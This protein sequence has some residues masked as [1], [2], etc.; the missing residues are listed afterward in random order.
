MR[1]ESSGDVQSPLH[2]RGDED[3]LQAL[4]RQRDSRF[5]MLRILAILLITAHH[6]L[7]FGADVCGYLTPYTPD[8]KGYAG[9]FA[10][11]VAVT[12]VSLFVMITGWF[13]VRRVW[14]PFFRLIIVCAVFGLVAFLL[15]QSQSF[16]PSPPWSSWWQS[17]KFT[18]WW[19]IVHYLMLLLVAPLLERAMASID[20]R[21]MEYILLALLVFNLVFGFAWGYVNASGYNV[22]HFVL[23]YVLARYLRLFPDA[24]VVRFVRSYAWIVLF[25][26]AVALGFIFLADTSGWQPKH[27]PMVWNYNCPLVILEAM[28]IFSLF[29]KQKSHKAQNSILLVARF[30]LGVYLLQSAPVMV[31]LRNAFGHWAY[32]WAGYAGLLLA[33]LV[34]AVACWVISCV[35][36]TALR[37][38]LRWARL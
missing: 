31:P 20:R 11:S 18:N 30:V 38:L 5:E 21:A 28:A 4:G 7:L 8:A 37:P 35:V 3:R 14:R 12:G 6:L 13:G 27:T 10:N 15:A 2:L 1:V 25:A 32:E 36:L 26:C 23:L 16:V 29:T 34:I 9:I 17:L 24:P 19:F 22:V 33:L